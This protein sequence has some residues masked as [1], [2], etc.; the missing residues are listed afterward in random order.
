MDNDDYINETDSSRRIGLA[1][2]G[3]GVRAAAFHLGVLSKLHEMGILQKV[4]IISSVSG[5]SLIA[6]KYGLDGLEDFSTFEKEMKSLLHKSIEFKTLRSMR[7]WIAV[8]IP[9]YTRT[10]A[11]ARAFDK[12]YFSKRTLSDLPTNPELIINA[13]NVNTGKNW[14][15]KRDEMGDYITARTKKVDDFKISRAV[16]ASCA[17]PPLI[18]PLRLSVKRYYDKTSYNAKIISLADG[19]LYDNQGTHSLL[20]TGNAK[21]RCTHI[22]CSDAAFPFNKNKRW[23]WSFTPYATLRYIDIL[24][25]QIRNLQFRNLVYGQHAE[26]V[27]SAFFAINWTVPYLLKLIKKNKPKEANAKLVE[28]LEKVTDNDLEQMEVDDE[29]GSKKRKELAVIL[30][31]P[32]LRDIISKRKVENIAKLGTRLKGLANSQINDLY[33][34]G[35]SLCGTQIRAY[36]SDLL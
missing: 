19:G 9:F 6:A 35:R 1:L 11:L 15:F 10:D 32:E 23:V 29:K 22:I 18:Y 24:M 17:A 33:L 21:N 36:C 34:H 7:F 31:I 3:G 5:G 14:K 20:P 8:L 13:T 4:D 12:L 26:S 30:D 28:K 2:S 16:T 27:S 25:V